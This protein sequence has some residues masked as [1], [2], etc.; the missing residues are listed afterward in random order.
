MKRLTL[1]LI[2]LAGLALT[3]CDLNSEQSAKNTLTVGNLVTPLAGGETVA[4][5]G[6]YSFDLNFTQ[7]TGIIGASKLS[8]DGSDHT[9]TASDASMTMGYLSN[10]TAGNIVIAL[11]KNPTIRIDGSSGLTVTNSQFLFTGGAIGQQCLV[12]N[13]QIGNEYRVR[14]FPINTVYVGE[15]QTTYPEGMTGETGSYKNSSMGY[16]VSIDIK[17][18]K[19]DVVIKDAKFSNSNNEPV[20]DV[21]IEKLDVVFSDGYYAIH[22]ENI[23]PKLLEGANFTEYPSFNIKSFDLTT[24]NP[25]FSAANI[26]YTVLHTMTVGNGDNKQEITVTYTGQCAGTCAYIPEGIK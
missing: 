11:I 4:S 16:Y 24:A 26:R 12:A 21:L 25:E 1:G 17:N 9:F 7:Q 6:T 2:A 14:T 5:E 13:Y 20:K 19:A 22:G 10:A 15:T 23:T 3:S 8:F 18:K